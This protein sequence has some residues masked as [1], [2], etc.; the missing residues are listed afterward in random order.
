[1]Y[2]FSRLKKSALNR[3]LNTEIVYFISIMEGDAKNIEEN[4]DIKFANL[5]L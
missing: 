3:T 2:M 4:V 5:S 1:M